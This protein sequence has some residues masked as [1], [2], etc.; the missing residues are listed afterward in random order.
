MSLRH[1]TRK[2][3]KS[4]PI[5]MS[6][7]DI[8]ARPKVIKQRINSATTDAL[9]E[10]TWDPE[11]RPG[12][13]NLLGILAQCGYISGGG[14]T[15]AQ[16]V[17]ADFAPGE[18]LGSLKKMTAD[19]L[20]HEL[21]GVADR[22]HEVLGS[23]GGKYIQELQELGAHRARESAYETMRMVRDAVGLGGPRYRARLPKTQEELFE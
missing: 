11:A 2:M 7:I 5:E 16:D 9:N 20:C 15:T 8:T 10:V 12:V 23:K 18:P 4:S 17:A 22:Y 14:A 6:R 13:A 21:A 1:P 3:S 19:A